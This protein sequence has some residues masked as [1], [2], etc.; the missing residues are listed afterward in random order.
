MA[1]IAIFCLLLKYSFLT[2]YI[3]IAIPS[4]IFILWITRPL[5]DWYGKAY[6]YGCQ[7][8]VVAELTRI[9]SD[10]IQIRRKKKLNK[11]D[12]YNGV[13]VKWQIQAIIRQDLA[14]E[15]FLIETVWNSKGEP[16]AR[17]RLSESPYRDLL[18]DQ[19]T[20]FRSPTKKII[21]ANT[22]S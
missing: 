12:A 4:L 19:F 21:H 8:Y 3:M 2:G 5:P 14:F 10:L 13:P 1:K 11:V 16:Y 20:L 18:K 15:L 6:P 17:Y 22:T 9:E 7:D